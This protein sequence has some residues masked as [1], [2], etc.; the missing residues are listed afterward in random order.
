MIAFFVELKESIPT[1]QRSMEGIW[2]VHF[3]KEASLEVVH[4]LG[5]VIAEVVIARQCF[6]LSDRS[7]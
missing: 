3:E 2:C 1:V 5:A 4:E 7:S 6:V